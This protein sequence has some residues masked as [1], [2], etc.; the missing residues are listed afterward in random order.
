MISAKKLSKDPNCSEEIKWK[1]Y[2][3]FSWLVYF[4]SS[5]EA[6][7]FEE[8]SWRTEWL[9]I[10][11]NSLYI[12]TNQMVNKR[13]LPR[14]YWIWPCI[15]GRPFLDARV[16]KD[17]IVRIGFPIKPG[18][19]DTN[20]NKTT[21]QGFF[22]MVLFLRIRRLSFSTVIFC[23]YSWF[24]DA[25]EYIVFST[26]RSKSLGI[27]RTNMSQITGKRYHISFFS[28]MFSSNICIYCIL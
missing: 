12:P 26:T 7:F 22:F 5:T 27:F 15:D 13:M 10:P 21:Y 28:P 11:L 2:F 24:Q 19:K 18:K 25:N 9:V 23:I 20:K 1:L 6:P 17:I 8:Q 4:K 14:W 16:A 3:D